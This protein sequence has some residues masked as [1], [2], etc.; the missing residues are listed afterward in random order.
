MRQL[1]QHGEVKQQSVASSQLEYRPN[2][3]NIYIS[4]RKAHGSS[5]VAPHPTGGGSTINGGYGATLS[6]HYSTIGEIFKLFFWFLTTDFDINSNMKVS[7]G[8]QQIFLEFKLQY[9]FRD[10]GTAQHTVTNDCWFVFLSTEYP[11][12]TFLLALFL[13]STSS[14]GR[15]V[16]LWLLNLKKR[17][18]RIH[19]YFCLCART[20]YVFCYFTEN[21]W[22]QKDE[23]SE[24]RH[25]QP[26]W[27]P[28]QWA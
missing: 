17:W 8:R 10:L 23:S 20:V 21:S 16:A 14:L 13:V 3:Q 15:Y 27:K 9:F 28:K 2:I 7:Q 1:L 26:S 24:S 5:L 6:S 19:L 4:N 18:N 22:I 12:F 11:I 25:K